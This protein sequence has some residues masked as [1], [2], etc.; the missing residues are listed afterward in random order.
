M[1]FEDYKKKYGKKYRD[2]A[3]E[4][5]RKANFEI[6]KKE[7]QD[8]ECDNCGVTVLFDKSK[9]E[10]ESNFVFSSRIKR[11]KAKRHWLKNFEALYTC[12]R[13]HAW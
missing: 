11:L 10:L 12:K 2:D 7:L 13:A 1:T 8:S 9:S 5:E 3:E 6:K 4:A